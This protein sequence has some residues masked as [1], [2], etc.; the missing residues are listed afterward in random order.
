[1]DKLSLIELSEATV[2]VKLIWSRR[3]DVVHL[4]PFT[5][6]NAI[7]L[8]AKIDFS[9][10]VDT[11]VQQL[12]SPSIIQAETLN[13]KLINPVGIGMQLVTR[14]MEGLEWEV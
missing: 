5:N 1:M 3:N 9:S 10:F 13:G 8:M 2:I 4:K 14:I 7:I 12:A 6:P 11:F